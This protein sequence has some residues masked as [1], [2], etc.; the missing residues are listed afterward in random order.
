MAILS[1]GNVGI[2]TTTPQS[3]LAVNGTVMATEI[4]V[5]ET[6]WADFVFED[7]YKLPSL[8]SIESY[9]KTHKHLPD[10]PSAKE[11]QKQ[12]LAVSEMLAKQMQKIEEM[13]LYLIQLKQENDRLKERVALLEEIGKT[14]NQDKINN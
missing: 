7:H 10:I 2:G 14:V 1:S 5:T 13:T 4:K 3:K 11:V 12:G 8:N 9:I 6:G